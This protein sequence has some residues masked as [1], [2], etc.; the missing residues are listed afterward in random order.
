VLIKAGSI[1]HRSINSVVKL[2]RD[3]LRDVEI[4]KSL[5]FVNDQHI[6]VDV[7]MREL[8]QAEVM[9]FQPYII[10]FL[11][12]STYTEQIIISGYAGPDA[13]QWSC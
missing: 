6:L 5:L 3:I 10:H 9:M 11:N 13:S 12:L 2:L 8:T 4:A 1:Q 7:I